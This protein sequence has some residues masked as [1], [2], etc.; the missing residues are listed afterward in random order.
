MHHAIDSQGMSDASER[1]GI[2]ADHRGIGKATT[3]KHKTSIS[4]RMS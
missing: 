1:E 4:Q 3:N 2:E